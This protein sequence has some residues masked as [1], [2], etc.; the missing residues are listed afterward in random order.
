[1][2]LPK[3]T[4]IY[5][6]FITINDNVIKIGDLKYAWFMLKKYNPSEKLSNEIL[7]FKRGFESSLS[8]Y[9]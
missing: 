5:N 9:E 8:Q 6:N 2:L 7:L 4:V 1:M 3:L